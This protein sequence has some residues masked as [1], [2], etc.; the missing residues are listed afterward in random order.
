MSAAVHSA[1]ALH[2]SL[3]LRSQSPLLLP[4][5]HRCPPLFLQLFSLP[6]RSSRFW[7]C[8]SL[9]AITRRC[10]RRCRCCFPSSQQ[11]QKL[12]FQA[13]SLGDPAV[14]SILTRSIGSNEAMSDTERIKEDVPND[15]SVNIV[16]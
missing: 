1:S 8:S 14:A 13:N 2:V 12:Y 10:R 3:Y 16:I 5:L 11:S 7:C 9:S 15:Q 4:L 6:W